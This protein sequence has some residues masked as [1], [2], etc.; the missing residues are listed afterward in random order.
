MEDPEGRRCKFCESPFAKYTCPRCNLAYCSGACY[1][2]ARHASCSE[3]FYRDWV[4]TY[5]QM[6]RADPEARRKMA[7]VLRSAHRED[8]DYEEEGLAES[9]RKVDLDDA[10]SAWGCLTDEERAQFEEL[11]ASGAAGRLVPI[12]QPWW[13]RSPLVSDADGADVAADVPPLSRLTTRPPAA[14]VVNSTVNVLCAYVYVARLYNGDLLPE[15][16]L[17]LTS[18]SAV[19]SEDALFGSASE[20]VQSALQRTLSLREGTTAEEFPAVL[21]S[22]CTLLQGAGLVD[23]IV[24]ALGD[25]RDLL[26]RAAVAG[27]RRKELRRAIK[28]AEYLVAWA[29]EHGRELLSCLP[30]VEAEALAVAENVASLRRA[31]E[32]VV[33]RAGDG[34][35]AS[36]PLVEELD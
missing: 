34:D 1:K 14:C 25:V 7:D 8:Q 35:V 30:D 27:Q 24:R 17:E 11:V 4:Q 31:G 12:W 21:A 13:E 29:H 10:G 22:L 28:K 20:A 19:L 15:S 26:R 36:R 33:R 18:I 3:D 23:N 6:E 5:L 16:A 2:D 32:T 9:L